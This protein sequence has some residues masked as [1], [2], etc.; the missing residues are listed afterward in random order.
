MLTSDNNNKLAETYREF[1][2]LMTNQDF[3]KEDSSDYKSLGRIGNLCFF[4]RDTNNKML[5]LQT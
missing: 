5:M 2:K 1:L 4:S 3:T